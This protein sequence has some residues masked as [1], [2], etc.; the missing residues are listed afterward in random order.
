MTTIEKLMQEQVVS[1]PASE[2]VDT[3]VA[4]MCQAGVGAI[5]LVEGEALAGIFTERDL[6]M[7]VVS[8]GLDPAKAPLREVSTL[9]VVSVGR[10]ASVRECA[11]VLQAQGVR[12]LP[13]TDDGKP[14]GVISSR[15][16]F[17]KVTGELETLIDRIRY[18]DAL[19]SMED[20]YD[21]IGG[22]YGR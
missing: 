6:L 19:Q 11:S 16:F 4:R 15:D 17:E 8:Q 9:D 21:H 10:S 20:P 2:N 12:H 22:S 14:V 1:V 13:V 5:L 18:D 7:Q 3:A